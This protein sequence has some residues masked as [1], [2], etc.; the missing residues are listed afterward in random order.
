MVKK[1][2]TTHTERYCQFCGRSEDEVTFLLEGLEACICADCVKIAD[3]YLDKIAEE[4]KAIASSE[5]IENEYK[6]KDIHAH[7]DQY[8]IGQERAKKLLPANRNV[9]VDRKLLAA[10]YEQFG[11]TRVK[12]V[13]KSVEIK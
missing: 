3:G 2:N 4:K 12:V 9:H 6:P 8:V 5:K 1:K 7:L 10:L 11:E 13:E